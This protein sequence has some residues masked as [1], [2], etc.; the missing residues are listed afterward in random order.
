[1]RN[2]FATAILCVA[3]ASSAASA[4]ES[5]M[6]T[7][8]TRLYQA[9]SNN[10]DFLNGDLQLSTTSARFTKRAGEMTLKRVGKMTTSADFELSG[11][12]IYRV[13]NARQ[14]FRGNARANGFCP[15]PVRWLAIRGA[16][17]IA[18]AAIRIC[19]LD[20]ESW[21]GYRPEKPGLCSCDTY[22]LAK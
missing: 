2:L 20:I 5:G 4:A 1:M 9:V 19:M 10:T 7:R 3:L 15:R 11:A 21:Q 12:T 17:D 22:T 16:P 18:P 14:Y 13:V 8:N 6:P